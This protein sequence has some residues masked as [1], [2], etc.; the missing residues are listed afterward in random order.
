M[1]SSVFIQQ[2]RILWTNRVNLV[3]FILGLNAEREKLDNTLVVVVILLLESQTTITARVCSRLV[4][5]DVNFRVSEMFVTACAGND[6]I[7][8]FDDGLLGDQIDGPVLVYD[9]S[10]VLEAHVS[11]I[12]LGVALKAMSTKVIQSQFDYNNKNFN[13]TYLARV[14]HFCAFVNNTKSTSNLCCDWSRCSPVSQL[15]QTRKFSKTRHFSRIFYF[16]QRSFVPSFIFVPKS[17]SEKWKIPLKSS[18]AVEIQMEKT[19]NGKI[20]CGD[21]AR[22][23]QGFLSFSYFSEKEPTTES[24][25]N[26]FKKFDAPDDEDDFDLEDLF[27]EFHGNSFNFHGFPPVIM[28]QFQEVLEAMQESNDEPENSQCKFNFESKYN[29]FRQKTDRDLDDKQYAEQLDLLLTRISP[30]LAPK[31]EQKKVKLS[32]QD[33]ILDIIHG[34]YEEIVPVKPRQKRNM[35][36]VPSPHHFGG[37]PPFNLQTSGQT[38]GKTVISIR[39]QDGSYETRK[40][41]RTPDGQTKTTITKTGTDGTSSTQS[42]TGEG[43][44][45]PILK[46]LL[47]PSGKHSERNLVLFDGYK[48]PCLW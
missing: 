48:I 11:V 5:V 15:R 25:Q 13:F 39:K 38:W 1:I 24:S 32:D 22:F 46:K 30:N 41:E 17:Y 4:Q 34:T 28:K 8:A 14:R 29:D 43:L 33:K 27:S 21:V 26:Y 36:K 10:S 19:R 3:S 7:C 2:M 9:L 18:S 31:T 12:I 42:F 40:L 47:P 45:Q 23:T 16:P 44:A 35:Q 6:T 20:S 37:I